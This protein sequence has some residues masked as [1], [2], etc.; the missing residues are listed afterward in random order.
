MTEPLIL[1]ENLVKIYKLNDIEVVALQGLDLKVEHG[2]VMSL[3]GSSGSGKTTL[4][5]VLGGLDRPSA[6][7][8]LV[9]G[10]DLLKA[11]NIALN[12]Y[13][14]RY[15]GFVWQQKARNLIPY[16]NAEQ[17]VELPM[18]MSGV[19][20][21]ARRAWARELVDAVGLGTRRGHRLAQL[22]GGEQQRVAIAV[23]LAN[24]PALL[25]ADEPTGELDSSTAAT[26]FEIFHSLNRTYG[27]TVVI[28]SH[29][30]QIAR[31]VGRVVAIRD[32][33]TSSETIRRSRD[34][35][36]EDQD[37]QAN[38]QPHSDGEGEHS[39]EE[40]VMLDSAGRLQVPKAVRDRYGIGDRVQ[41]EETPDGLLLRPVAG[42]EPIKRL[43]APDAPPPKKAR[44]LTRLLNTVRRR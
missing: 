8:V 39:F 11:S 20:R 32:G 15:V 23:A 7:K 44:G 9:A 17:N 6:G 36:A 18:V 25:L 16:L 43:A 40:L 28:V 12:H 10:N 3:V 37:A 30:P 22:S 2:E 13:R 19:G 26:I 33:K 42:V 1:C 35:R 14:R 4:L 5:N 27:L 38:G 31:Y 29:D 34:P 24:R 41:M 21:R